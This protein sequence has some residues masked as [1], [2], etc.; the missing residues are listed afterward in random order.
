MSEKEARLY[1]AQLLLAIEYLHSIGVIHRDIKP[2][3]ILI[4]ATGNLKLTDFGI[5]RKLDD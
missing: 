2:E 5:S 4:D 1:G 3:N